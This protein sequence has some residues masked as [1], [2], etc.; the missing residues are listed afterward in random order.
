MENT[1]GAIFML[2]GLIFG[3]LYLSGHIFLW[4]VKNKFTRVYYSYQWILAT[5][6]FII[7]S[8]MLFISTVFVGFFPNKYSLLSGSQSVFIVM[9]LI[10]LILTIVYFIIGVGQI[11]RIAMIRPVEEKGKKLEFPSNKGA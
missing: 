6:F 2:C 8:M 5:I 10:F 7:F 3:V 1:W 4:P 11:R 9:I